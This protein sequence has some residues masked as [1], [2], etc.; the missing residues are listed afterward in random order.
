MRPK[1]VVSLRCLALSSKRGLA[2]RATLMVLA[3]AAIVV[4]SAGDCLAGWRERRAAAQQHQAAGYNAKV[5]HQ[6][7]RYQPYDARA[8]YPKYY[9]GIHARHLQNIGIPSGDI[10]LRG[11]SITPNAW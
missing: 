7:Y 9:G 6:P 11:N 4:S 8:V 10:G 2:M 3:V 5:Q 1:R